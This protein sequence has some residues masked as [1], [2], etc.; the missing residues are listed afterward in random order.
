MKNSH[1]KEK[2]HNSPELADLHEAGKSPL[3]IM[4]KELQKL[5]FI[6]FLYTNI[7]I[8]NHNSYIYIYIYIHPIDSRR[9]LIKHSFF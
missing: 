3:S 7:E 6:N 9:S 1:K 2:T 4:S 5:S 8:L